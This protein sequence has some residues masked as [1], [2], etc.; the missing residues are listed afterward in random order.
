[1]GHK[2][3]GREAVS[4]Q[5]VPCPQESPCQAGF[6]PPCTCGGER[7]LVVPG[8]CRQGPCTES[9]PRQH[10]HHIAAGTGIALERYHASGRSWRH[11][12]CCLSMAVHCPGS[13]SSLC[14]GASIPHGLTCRSRGG[15]QVLCWNGEQAGAGG[16]RAEQAGGLRA[17]SH[18]LCPGPTW[19]KAQAGKGGKLQELDKGCGRW[20]HGAGSGLPQE[21]RSGS[22]D[23]R[24]SSS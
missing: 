9:S 2:P 10:G 22:W 19:Q 17:A 6:A 15:Q 16:A 3:G 24:F 12:S 14:P 7:A 8:Q 20:R 23:P 21:S 4:M 5:A 11:F 1:M 18:V 13:W